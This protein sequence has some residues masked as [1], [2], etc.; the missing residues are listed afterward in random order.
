[1]NKNDVF[2]K[3]DLGRAEISN[4]NSNALLREA[5]TL[6]IFIDGQKT[7]QQY[8][9][10]L[11]KGKMFE[12][13]GG[14]APFFEL[15]V[16]LGYVE[17][18]NSGDSYVQDDRDN[19]Q[20]NATLETNDAIQNKP[21]TALT[22]ERAVTTGVDDLPSTTPLDNHEFDRFFT[23]S[24]SEP[25]PTS[26]DTSSGTKRDSVDINLEAVKSKLATYI[27]QRASAQDVWGYMLNLEQC[28]TVSALQDFISD[29]ERT[30]NQQ[31]SQDISEFSK[32]LER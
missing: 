14:I 15:L 19:M 4:Q 13:A 8:E 28:E 11:D 1:M 9:A 20:D 29:I 25:T 30:D 23:D 10:L 27:E 32:M 2:Q 3:S 12:G 24:P 7:Y 16:D 17:R 6:L 18:V 31:L 26:T 5:R 21:A 22:S